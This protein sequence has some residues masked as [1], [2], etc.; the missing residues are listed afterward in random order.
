M[1]E[2]ATCCLHV[3]TAE[4][5]STGFAR[6]H[7]ATNFA[8]GQ[9]ISSLASASTERHLRRPDARNDLAYPE[10]QKGARKTKFPSPCW[11]TQLAE[12]AGK[13][14]P[15]VTC[16]LMPRKHRTPREHLASDSFGSGGEATSAAAGFY[17]VRVLECESAAGQIGVEIDLCAVEVQ[18]AF[19]V[20]HDTNTMV[21]FH[22]V[23]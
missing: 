14:I 20:H 11:S 8:F 16:F 17:R 23:V 6:Q 10:Q 2:P 12:N 21:F 4:C 15:R 9:A 13:L 22:E 1:S 5:R 3:T 18:V 7:L 19:L